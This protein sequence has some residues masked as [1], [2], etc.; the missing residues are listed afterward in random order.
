MSNPSYE[1]SS[2]TRNELKGIRRMMELGF[3]LVLFYGNNPFHLPESHEIGKTTR[4]PGHDFAMTTQ[5]G[6]IIGY[7]DYANAGNGQYRYSPAQDKKLPKVI[8]DYR[9][10]KEVEVV[11]DQATRVAT[12]TTGDTIIT[13][14]G[15][16]VFDRLDHIL[17]EINGE[18]YR[19]NTGYWAWRIEMIP[20][21]EA[22]SKPFSNGVPVVMNG[23]VRL[24]VTGYAYED[25]SFLHYLGVVGHKTGIESLRATM[26]QGKPFYMEVNGSPVSFYPLPKYEQVW[27]PMPEY[28]SHH[29]AFIAHQALPGKWTPDDNTISL[30]VF[31]GTDGAENP[32][33]EIKRQ[34]ISRLNEALEIPIVP[35]WADAL[36]EA[37]KLTRFVRKLT[38]GGDCI[39]GIL[40]NLNADW[41]HL[42]ETLLEE[43]K[44]VVA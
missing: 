44:I 26:V 2:Y 30:L 29:S 10:P 41:N 3:N 39:A 24:A 20:D 23:Q 13:F 16:N 37:A 36:W 1:M 8:E 31:R 28:S 40:I 7:L 17:D 21:P 9:A 4:Y 12:I 25:N 38:V 27:Q 14:T 15:V 42:V 6:E 35:E 32:A 33:A 19:L 18:L 11:L 43:G 34:F 22:A 5:N